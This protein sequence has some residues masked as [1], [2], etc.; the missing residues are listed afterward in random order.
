MLILIA[1]ESPPQVLDII[2]R[3]LAFI[4]INYNLTGGDMCITNDKAGKYHANH[5]DVLADISKYR[6]TNNRIAMQLGIENQ[7]SIGR[8]RNTPLSLNDIT[9]NYGTENKSIYT[10]GLEKGI[11]QGTEEGWHQL[12]A[13]IKLIRAGT[14]TDELLSMEYS[15]ELIDIAASLI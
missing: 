10:I 8:E 5:P 14:S 1:V 11:E 13:V 12:A 6:T 9:Y 3:N 7:S 4:S 15:Q 2:L